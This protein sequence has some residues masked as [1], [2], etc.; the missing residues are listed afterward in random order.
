VIDPEEP[1]VLAY[2]LREGRY[3]EVGRASGPTELRLDLPFPV[4][5]TPSALTD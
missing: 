3:V 2:E 1:A 5:L 4:S